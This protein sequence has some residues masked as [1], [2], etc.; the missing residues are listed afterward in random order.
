MQ[1]LAALGLEK[2]SDAER[3]VLLR[4]WSHHDYRLAKN[5]RREV[6]T[7]YFLRYFFGCRLWVLRGRWPVVGI[8]PLRYDIFADGHIVNLEIEFILS[9]DSLKNK[10]R[11][12]SQP[13]RYTALSW[14]LL[15]NSS[16]PSNLL[17]WYYFKTDYSRH[18]NLRQVN[19]A[20]GWMW[21]LEMLRKLCN[22]R[23]KVPL[24]W[25]WYYLR[26]HRFTTSFF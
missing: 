15:S 5:V 3:R 19:I 24:V 10:T 17:G 12:R 11:K 6:G 4:L 9:F 26:K 21:S 23:A 16:G 14:K 18:T 13:L 22:S 7:P 8:E 1:R 20:T 2:S 25:Y